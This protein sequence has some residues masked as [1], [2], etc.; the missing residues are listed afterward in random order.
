MEKGDT[1]FFVLFDFIFK[2][3][4]ENFISLIALL[5]KTNSP[6][7]VLVVASFRKYG[8]REMASGKGHMYNQNTHYVACHG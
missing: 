1:P 2:I 8:F 5:G 6:E 4:S 7:S 3:D